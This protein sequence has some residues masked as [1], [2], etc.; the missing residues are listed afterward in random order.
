[1]SRK[2]TDIEKTWYFNQIEA[3]GG[4]AVS[5][6]AST[7]TVTYDSRIRSDESHAKAATQEEL[8]H[9]VMI[10]LLHSDEYSYKLE[11]LG[12]EIYFHHGSKGSNADEVDILVWDED[13]LP[14]ALV[15]LK[16]ASEFEGKRD[17]TIKGQLFGTAPLVGSLKLLV[18]ATVDPS[19]PRPTIKCVCIDYTKHKDYDSWVAAGSPSSST[20]PAEYM[21]LT[22]EP[23][24][25]GSQNDLKLDSSQ[26]DFR[27]VAAGFHN[28]F[29]GEHPDNAIFV[30]LVKCLLAKIHDERTRKNGETY[31]F[32]VL[33]RNG[34]PESA[35]AVFARV[36]DLYKTAYVRYIDP[37]SGE[38]DFIDN[39]EF[40]EERVKAVVL[41]LQALSITKGAAR[42]GDIIG[43][44]FEQ[45]LRSGFKQDRGMYF[46]H[47]NI[48]RFMV[49]AV[50]LPGLARS[51]WSASTHPNN[52]LPYVIDPACGSGTFLLQSMSTITDTIRRSQNDLVVDHDS[53]QFYD[54]RLSESQPNGWAADFIYGLDPKFIMAITAKVNMVLH[55]DGSA[56]VYK[57][58]AFASLGT[59]PPDSRLGAKAVQHRSVSPASYSP[60]L[61]ESFDVVISN[62]PFGVTLAA[63]TRRTLGKTFELPESTTSEGLFLERCFQLLKPLGRMAVVLP[64]SVIN[65][66][67][68]VATRRL[69]FRF[70]NVRS[71]VSL[72]RNLFIDTPTLTSLVFAQKKT[73][74]EIAEWD[75]V[76]QSKEATVERQV[77]AAEFFLSKGYSAG[78]SAAEIRDSVI[79]ALSPTFSARDWVSK[80]GR[81]S[82]HLP[83]APAWS[84]ELGGVA[85]AY[86]RGIFRS[87]S[88]VNLRTNRVFA[89]AAADL[90][91]SLMAYQVTE[92]G[93]KL[94][95]RGERARPNQ[96]A[97]FRGRKS[98]DEITNLHL[99]REE[100]EVRV[101]VADPQNVL[102]SIRRDVKWSVA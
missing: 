8:C 64:E 72:P 18:Y 4:K 30:N 80:P 13:R 63:E 49:E 87:A 3:L 10:A 7:Q 59:Y 34:K 42:N 74:E 2:L 70:F 40:S 71:V 97:Q 90:D 89:M 54:A 98:G 48:A 20:F 31:N 102:D 21:D 43:A 66:K 77:K 1:M 101:N 17:A 68:M 76:L 67:D 46:T 11:S 58:D 96:L 79:A 82:L 23:L 65:S 36:N 6:S 38:R 24:A 83:F 93:Y 92:V 22:F 15:E 52:R 5:A 84:D 78:H 95:K 73:K 27:A 91:S 85:A 56:H 41:A 88:F 60:D 86:Y 55:G 99:A 14:Y 53:R 39:K 94:S 37:T 9:A 29:F 44:F 51:I 33:Y 75:A 50:D 81:A 61:C 28:E 16:A 26:A 32:Q 62:P 57:E 12:H 69:L 47:D 45:I 25:S 100:A 35:E 19:G